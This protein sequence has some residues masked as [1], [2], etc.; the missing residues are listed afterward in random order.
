VSLT[1]NA[2]MKSNYYLIPTL[3]FFIACNKTVDEPITP[4]ESLMVGKWRQTEAYIS[5]GGPQYWVDTEHGEEIEFF[6]NGTFSSDR[7]SECTTGIFSIEEDK[8]L[9]EYN[10]SGFDTEAENDEGIIT[11]NLELF[12]DYFILTPTSGPI[13]I[14]G[15]SYKY[16]TIE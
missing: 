14:E 11:Y 6:E 12:S 16:Q 2:N 5:S 13:C 10:C 9:L 15:C 4:D 7:F 3:L 1:K 8:L